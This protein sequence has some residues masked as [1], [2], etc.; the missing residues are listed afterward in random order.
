[1]IARI[2]PRK[3]SFTP[4]D[5]HAYTDAPGLF[6]PRYKE[7]HISCVFS[8]D[9][10]TAEYLAKQWEG[11]AEKV[12]IGGPAYNSP[13]VDFVPNRYLKKGVTIT[14]R[15]C[16]NNCGYCFVPRREGKLKELTICEGNIIQDNNILQASDKHI[17]EV[18][19]MLKK[20]P[21]AVF[22]GGLDVF[23]ITPKVVDLLRS[24]KISQMFLAYD[25]PGQREPLKKAIELLKPYFTPR[26]IR[27]YCLIGME[28]DTLE[29]AR[30]RLDYVISLGA[31][32]FAQRMRILSR[33]FKTSLIKTDRP[34]NLLQREYSNATILMSKF[35]KVL[36]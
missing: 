22:S 9:M 14:T 32:P 17:E 3:T 26:Q 28:S 33:D 24:I 4:D 18:F 1:M 6:T 31:A 13:A 8:W 16:N 5:E 36:T 21:P 34:W 29:A 25:K 2:F 11:H 27:V 30:E 35:K 20:Q 10:D 19:K 23:R 7:A 12:L 15:G